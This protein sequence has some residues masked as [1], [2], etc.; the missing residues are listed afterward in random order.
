[1]TAECQDRK[2]LVV[3]VS[4]ASG[5]ALA[6]HLLRL[7]RELPDWETHLI[8]TRGGEMTI[9][10]ETDMSPDEVKGLASVVYDNDD[11]GAAIASG[12]FSTRGMVVIPCSMKTAAGIYSGYADNLLLRAADVT[13]KE[14]RPLALLARESPLSSI[15]LRNLYG[16]SRMGV[17][18]LPPLMSFYNHP[19]SIDDMIHHIVCKALKMWDIQV[20]GFQIWR[21]RKTTDA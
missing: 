14:K 11:A 8:I 6:V 9:R 16:L 10:E 3:G 5:A 4:G 15:H 18:I 19:A 7:V 13:L 2:R 17:S 12:T 20:P 21:G 1:V